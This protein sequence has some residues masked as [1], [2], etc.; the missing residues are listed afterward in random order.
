MSLSRTHGIPRRGS[1]ADMS[2]RLSVLH[3]VRGPR[4]QHPCVIGFTWSKVMLERGPLVQASERE[5]TPR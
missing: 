5:A 3:R 2:W 1:L 4:R